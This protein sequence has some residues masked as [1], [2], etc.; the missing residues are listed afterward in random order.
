MPNQNVEQKVEEVL[1]VSPNPDRPE[2]TRTQIRYSHLDMSNNPDRNTLFKNMSITK[3]RKEIEKGAGEFAGWNWY[4]RL[5]A[6]V[7]KPV[8]TGDNAVALIGFG[9]SS[10]EEVMKHQDTLFIF[11]IC[12]QACLVGC[13][14]QFEETDTML[15]TMLAQLHHLYLNEAGCRFAYSPTRLA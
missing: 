11:P 3:M 9:R 8:I 13:R 7:N 6:D 10:R 2:D 4:L 5:T 15:P 1:Q 12:W 14:Q